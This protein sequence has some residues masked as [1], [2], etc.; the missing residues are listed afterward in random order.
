VGD[1]NALGLSACLCVPYRPEVGKA[2][3]T[4]CQYVVIL[5]VNVKNWVWSKS[6]GSAGHGTCDELCEKVTGDLGA[7]WCS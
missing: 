1:G 3:A 2:K 6:V 4:G 7:E 5:N